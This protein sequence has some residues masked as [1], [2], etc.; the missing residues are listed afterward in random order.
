MAHETEETYVVASSMDWGRRVFDALPADLRERTELIGGRDELNLENLR[1][2][3]P[4]FVFLPHWSYK[5]PSEVF[6]EFDCV[7]FHMTD[8]PYGRGGSPLQNLIMRGHTETRVS[9]LR[10]VEQM[11]A[12]PIYLKAPLSLAG[13]AAEIFVRL[14]P[15]VAG[16]IAEI[17]ATDPEPVAQTGEPT[18]FVRRK[19]AD[20]TLLN[21]PS[22]QVAYDMIR[23]LDADG[24][25]DAFLE[26]D[27]LRFEFSNAELKDGSLEAR[28]VVK[29]RQG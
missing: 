4:K 27:T 29:P 11:D 28:V 6:S 14:T 8:L 9:A 3:N 23:M 20:G 25:P 21:A 22:L 17:V 13:S 26:T 24:Y 7:I 10:C 16:M 15:I 1:R 19:P 18:E 2:I 5:I 12:G